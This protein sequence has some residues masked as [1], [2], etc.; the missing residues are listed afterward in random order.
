MKE[1]PSPAD[2]RFSM[3]ASATAGTQSLFRWRC[4]PGALVMAAGGSR[5]KRS[6]PRTGDV[7]ASTGSAA[8]AKK[9]A[10]PLKKAL[11]AA[12]F[13][14]CFTGRGD[15][16]LEQYSHL[17]CADLDDLDDQQ[18]ASA[19]EKFRA[20][21]HVVLAF[22]SP[23]GTGLKVVFAVAGDA[24]QHLQN[25]QAVKAHVSGGYGL[26]VDR[27]CKNLERLCFVSYDPAAHF[28][29][30]AVPLAPLEQSVQKHSVPSAP[31]SARRGGAR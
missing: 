8:D 21:P 1:T 15:N 7:L 16:K 13:S 23:T 18:Q 31:C 11:P 17:L 5:W 30:A 29:P 12:M 14:G 10:G 3:V 6:A 24:Q 25:F 20:D 27:A 2:V 9:A 4:S 28:N 22:L 26:A 19:S